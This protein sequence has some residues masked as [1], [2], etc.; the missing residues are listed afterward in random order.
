MGEASD[1]ESCRLGDSGGS[2]GLIVFAHNLSSME[3][4]A[5]NKRRHTPQV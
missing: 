4:R 3:Y 2:C 1:F 5:L